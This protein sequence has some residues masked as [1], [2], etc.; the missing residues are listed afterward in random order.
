MTGRPGGRGT[1]AMT[2]GAAVASLALAVPS[3]SAASRATGR[4]APGPQP[5]VMILMDTHGAEYSRRLLLEREVALTYLAAGVRAGL[6]TFSTSWRLVLAPT[7]DHARTVRAVG[8]V[9]AGGPTSTAIHRAIAA[10]ESLI[11]RLRAPSS[12]LLVLSNGEEIPG[13]PIKPVIPVDVIR[14]RFDADDNM[15]GLAALAGT[16]GGHVAD[17]AQAAWLAGVFRPATTVPPSGLAGA[18]KPW[19]LACGLAGVFAVLVI[20]S[21]MVLVCM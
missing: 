21:F 1:A 2:L 5:V 17:P 4:A 11:T 12:R 19:L 3:A 7:T 13:Q 18:A 6:I 16:S 8:A 9:R 14:W 10:A 20:A 15:A